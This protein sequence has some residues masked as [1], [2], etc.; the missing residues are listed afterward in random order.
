MRT[1]PDFENILQSQLLIVPSPDWLTP[2]VWFTVSL[3]CSRTGTT[4]YLITSVPLCAINTFR[5]R[6]GHGVPLLLGE[7]F[8]SYRLHNGVASLG[9]QH[10]KCCHTPVIL[11]SS[12]GCSPECHLKGNREELTFPA[13]P[14]WGHLP[15]RYTNSA[16]TSVPRNESE[17]AMSK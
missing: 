4:I 2:P 13:S 5:G 11:C 9:G 17:A 12:G 8:R 15:L 16:E 3:C 10:C 7:D 14:S 6:R 1:W